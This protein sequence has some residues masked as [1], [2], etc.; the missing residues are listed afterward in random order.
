MVINNCNQIQ[1]LSH[2]QIIATHPVLI[3]IP[4]FGGCVS[5]S[6]VK[7]E[8][9]FKIT[10][11]KPSLIS[12]EPTSETSSMPARLTAEVLS[13]TT[14]MVSKAQPISTE[15]ISE[16]LSTTTGTISETPSMSTELTSETL[17]TT[18]GIVSEIP[19]MFTE[20]TSETSSIPTGMTSETSS[21]T[22]KTTQEVLPTSAEPA[23]VTPSV[24]LKMIPETKDTDEAKSNNKLTVVSAITA[25]AVCSV[26]T[27]GCCFGYN[28]PKIK[29]YFCKPK[30][31]NNNPTEKHYDQDDEHMYD[32]V[33]YDKYNQ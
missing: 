11:P 17:S 33:P 19:S 13:T 23:S 32:T 29:N 27:V 24:T 16:T 22:Q 2:G 21:I 20:L 6:K 14:R 28:I 30:K 3:S 10:V 25:V 4:K 8:E 1:F 26:S 18:T 7:E 12:T 5:F 31:Q 9:I 15:I